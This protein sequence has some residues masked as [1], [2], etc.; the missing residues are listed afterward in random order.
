[1]E[2][3]EGEP[4]DAYC[5]S[6]ALSTEA[7][8]DL[9]IEVCN[10]VEAA[11]RQLI[12]HRDIKPGNILVSADGRAKLI[13]FGIAKHMGPAPDTGLTR[14][15]GTLF[16]SH[17]AAPEQVSGQEIS[18]AT[19]VFSLGALAYRVLT[20]QKIF[21]GAVRN[22]Y[23]YL[24]AVTRQDVTVPRGA[25]AQ[26]EIASDLERI[27]L[28][29][30]ARD[31]KQR[32]PSAAEF[33]AEFVR[34]LK[35][36]PIRARAPSVGYR[37]GK[38]LRRNRAAVAL[39]VLL[40]I[41]SLIGLTTYVRQAQ[42]VATERD[43]A[44]RAAQRASLEARRTQQIN[45]FL[46]QV[47]QSADPRL[48][49]RE[50]T[51]AAALDQAIAK[52]DATLAD[53]PDLAGDVLMTI[54]STDASMGRFDQAIKTAER[55]LVYLRKLPER[56]IA[57]ASAQADIGEWHE[58]AGNADAGEAALRP[59]VDA[60]R[61]LAPAGA[62][63]AEAE[64]QLATVY[65]NTGRSKEAEQ[66]FVSA[67]RIQRQRGVRD[68]ALARVVN[69]YAVLLG[70][71]GR[72]ADALPLHRE[73]LD[74]A[75]AAQGAD[76][77]FVD[78]VR[79]G[80]AGA[81]GFTGQVVASLSV[82]R[83][84]FARRERV[85]GPKHLDTLWSKTAVANALVDLKR[86]AEAETV[87]SESFRDLLATEGPAHQVTLFAQTVLGRAQCG[88]GAHAAALATLRDVADR[89]LKLYG[90]KHWLP[91]NSRVLLARCMISAKRLGD[92]EQLL[93]PAIATL[94]STQGSAFQRTQEAYADAANLYALRGDTQRAADW[95]AR[96]KPA[97]ASP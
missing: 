88:R 28:K 55:A 91:A 97:D 85:L 75:I 90:P 45:Q 95:R 23:E 17:Y 57:V 9:L 71:S 73:A 53:D 74:I 22:D 48:G 19:D 65:T 31:P 30:L 44:T 51:V 77:P 94:E 64:R 29:A 24:S 34:Y 13:D 39:A 1:M 50:V 86:F 63:L 49:N 47:L 14:D 60:L 25:G 79:A 89:R 35:H 41:A 16:T 36:L 93:L 12:V 40:S 10:A 62:E 26:R 82:F 96:L 69:D 56:D 8:L 87:S 6:R 37:L 4:I 80:L 7:R 61:R 46:T 78:D 5:D 68:L 15:T 83:E 54:A 2:F 42:Q 38:Y 33:A 32:Y 59:A 70:S 84:I 67:L 92:A 76:S 11:H 72:A 43:R 81:L 21:A 27:L 52:V 20:G 58:L 66:L 18:T 3:V